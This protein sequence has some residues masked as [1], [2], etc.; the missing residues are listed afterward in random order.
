MSV[1]REH[2]LVLIGYN[3]VGDADV[4]GAAGH[5]GERGVLLGLQV[6]GHLKECLDDFVVKFLHAF[7]QGGLDKRMH[8]GQ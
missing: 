5:A 8:Q 3:G 4:V 7:F 6:L 1:K 2:E